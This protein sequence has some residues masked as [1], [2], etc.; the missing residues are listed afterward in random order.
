VHQARRHVGGDADVALAA[1]Q[2]QGDGGGVVAG[3]DGEALGHLADQPLRALDVAGGFL[4]ADDAR[5]L[6][7]AQHGVVLHIG[8]GAAGHVVQH[9][10]QVAGGLGNGLEV[11]VLAFLRRLVVVGHHLQLAIGADL[12]GELAPARWLRPWSWRRNRP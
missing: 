12:L 5:H 10:R 4:D 3:V 6:G 7:Q 8:D 2:H 9:H 11:L 1:A